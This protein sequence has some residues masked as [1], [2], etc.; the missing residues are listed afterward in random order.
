MEYEDRLT[1][2]TPEGVELELTLAGFASRS[3][4]GLIDL[5]L[6]L[7]VMAALGVGLGFLLSG[8]VGL[9]GELVAAVITPLSF[10]VYVA[11]DVPFETRGGGRT[12]GKRLNGLRVVRTEGQPVGFVASAVRNLIRLI[13]GAPLLYVPGMISILAS[14]RNQRLGDLAAGTV[15]I[16]ERVGTRAERRQAVDLPALDEHAAVWDVSGVSAEEV[17]T[18]RRF[19]ERREM[20]TSE[21]RGHLADELAERL[22]PKVAGPADEDPAEAFLERLVAAKAARG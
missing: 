2:S 18:V 7:V 13:D 8:P 22:R 5:L 14:R 11:Y 16:R 19:L 15:V 9:S 3:I 10:L 21:A 20:L 17:A 12:P 4:A 6:K 1:I